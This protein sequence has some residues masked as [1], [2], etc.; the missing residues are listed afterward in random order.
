M[1]MVAY[2]TCCDTRCSVSSGTVMLRG[3]AISWHSRSQEVTASGRSE[4]EYDALAETVKEVPFL[5]QVRAFILPSLLNSPII[6]HEYNQG[7]IMMVKIKLSSKRT[8]LIY[9]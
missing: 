6:L 7:A 9:V 8:R 2:A 5:R 4:A 1:E 3:G